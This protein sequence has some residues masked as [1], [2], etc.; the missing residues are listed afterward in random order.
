MKE[1]SNNLVPGKKLHRILETLD[2]G[3]LIADATGHILYTNHAF[4]L[5]LG[6][7]RKTKKI[8][9]HLEKITLFSLKN[10]REISAQKL[11]LQLQKKG[12]IRNYQGLLKSTRLD[13]ECDPVVTLKAAQLVNEEGV[14]EGAVFTIIDITKEKENSFQ[15]QQFI[16]TIGHE[17]KHPLS[18][19]KAYLYYL[20]KMVK[21]NKADAGEYIEKMSNQIDLLTNMLHDVLDITK[22][23]SSQFTITPQ[24][25]EIN[26]FLEKVITD[27]QPV[28]KNHHLILQK[29]EQSWVYFDELR[30]QQVIMN[31]LSNAAKYSP[32]SHEI[33]I[34]VI[35]K[36]KRVHIQVIDKGIGIPAGEIRSI[37]RPYFRSSATQKKNFNGLGLGLYLCS[38]I[39][40]KHHGNVGAQ[41]T[42]GS[43]TTIT[44][45]LPLIKDK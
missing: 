10:G 21:N 15:Q 26:T 12:K 25:G 27:L 41:S 8:P 30:M 18:C 39:I 40:E 16:H 22:I 17:L 43:G 31:L 37:F 2:D 35:A 5:L 36:K 9:Q 28:Y 29:S 14:F 3:L 34:K 4:S 24:E 32:D 7:G 44:I 38:E 33:I 45:S 23:S 42:N 19:M 6:A 13:R 11:L 20:K 1:L